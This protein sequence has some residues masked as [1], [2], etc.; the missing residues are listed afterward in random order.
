L[1]NISFRDLAIQK[2][3]NDLVAASFGRSFYILD[4]YSF[5]REF[6]EDMLNEEAVLFPLRD[7]D[8]YMP[9]G[10]GR[11]KSGS[12]GGQHFVGS[13]PDFGA[14]FTYYLKEGQETIAS[15]RK[16]AESE[17]N[18][19]NKDIDF[20][21]WEELSKEKDE[22]KE[23]HWLVI[24]NSQKK[25]IRKMKVPSGKG[26]HRVTWNLRA[27][28]IMPIGEWEKP[29][30]NKEGGFLVS[31]GNYSAQ[32]YRLYDG[33]STAVD[34]PVAFTVSPLFKNSIQPKNNSIKEAFLVK[35][36]AVST[37]KSLLEYDYNKLKNNAKAMQVAVICWV[38]LRKK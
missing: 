7:A 26:L 15:K 3:E 6:T 5:L 21:G 9:L 8:L 33:V 16:K 35:Y 30:G 14:Q 18:K 28:K 2:R 23:Q 11:Q 37:R 12:L 24:I 31:P 22:P 38:T 34:G 32:L 19:T 27:E 13:N 29:N 10:D 4:D 36:K 20:P 1:P 17:L 25:V